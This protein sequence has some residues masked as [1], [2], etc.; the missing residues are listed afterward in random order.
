MILILPKI[1]ESECS[2]LRR[3][4]A[5]RKFY[6][7]SDQGT[8]FLQV[9]FLAKMISCDSNYF[10]NIFFNTLVFI[11]FIL[12]KKNQAVRNFNLGSYNL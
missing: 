4:E 5:A 7:S 6:W 11:L 2:I 10:M 12:I 1:V 9:Y 8:P 3:G